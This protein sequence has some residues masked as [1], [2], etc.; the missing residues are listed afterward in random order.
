[1]ALADMKINDYIGNKPYK[2][3]CGTVHR[4]DIDEIVI[5]KG[6]VNDAGA[7]LERSINKN[8]DTFD[9]SKHSVFILADENTY[10]AA[11]EKTERSIAGRGYKVNKLIL[12]GDRQVVPDEK[13]VFKIFNAIGLDD[14]YIVA[15]GSGTINDIC[16][17]LSFKLGKPYMIVA[18]AP[19]MDGFASPV[20]P[21]VVNNIKT[22]FISTTPRAI[23]GDPD[24]LKEAPASL[25]A[26]GLGDIL[27]KYNA[28]CDWNNSRVITGEEYCPEIA[29]MVEVAT[30]KCEQSAGGLSERNEESIGLL[31]E[32]LC[33]TGIAMSFWGYSRP[34]SSAEHHIAHFWEMTFLN[35]HKEA[36]LHGAKVGIAS[37][38]AAKMQYFLAEKLSQSASGDLFAAAISAAK[39]F[40]FDN[41]ADEARVHYRDGADEIILRESEVGYYQPENR[42]KRINAIKNNVSEIIG[43]IKKYTPAEERIRELIISAGGPAYPADVG[44]SDATVCDALLHAKEI[45][46]LCTVLQILSD[47]NLLEEFTE[48]R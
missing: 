9:K 20:A 24:I 44:I 30:K 43:N 36:V 40:D 27:G 4:A 22:S 28:L 8:C 11:G 33:L 15:A 35:E 21:L 39:N 37:A 42:I 31:M 48:R 41:W 45:R 19:S 32:A 14:K 25:I 29:G 2:C 5:K 46:A 1:M 38:Y 10:K 17:Y 6:A 34:A 18:T 7:V 3:S 26:A 16:R 47:L 12:P 23:V 13:T